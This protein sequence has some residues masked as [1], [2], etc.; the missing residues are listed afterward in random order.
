MISSYLRP[1]PSVFAC[2]VPLAFYSAAFAQITVPALLLCVLE[3]SPASAKALADALNGY[4]F[5]PFS[6]EL[7]TDFARAGSLYENDDTYT[8]SESRLT[9]TGGISPSPAD[10]PSAQTPAESRSEPHDGSGR[11]G[12]RPGKAELGPVSGAAAAVGTCLKS[13]QFMRVYATRLAGGAAPAILRARRKP[14]AGGDGEQTRPTECWLSGKP[15]PTEPG[16][17]QHSKANRVDGASGVCETATEDRAGLW[18]PFGA[19]AEQ[20]V[21]ASTGTRPAPSHAGPPG[22]A[23]GASQSK[24]APLCGGRTFGGKARLRRV[25]REGLGGN[26]LEAFAGFWESLDLQSAAAAALL[27][28]CSA[29][30]LLLAE[31]QLDKLHPDEAL[32]DAL[33]VV[34][35]MWQQCHL[36]SMPQAHFV[37]ILQRILAGRGESTTLATA[38]LGKAKPCP[39]SG[40]TE[41]SLSS[42]SSDGGRVEGARTGQGF[43]GPQTANVDFS[44]MGPEAAGPFIELRKMLET[45]FRPASSAAVLT[46][47][48]PAPLLQ[49]VCHALVS[50][51]DEEGTAVAECLSTWHTAGFLLQKAILRRDHLSVLSFHELQLQ[52]LMGRRARL[53]GL[54]GDPNH[55][56]SLTRIHRLDHLFSAK[57]LDSART[58]GALGLATVQDRLLSCLGAPASESG[59][60]GPAVANRRAVVAS[61]IDDA[62]PYALDA[63]RRRGRS[64]DDS[65]RGGMARCEDAAERPHSHWL[66]S[67]YE[68]L[69]RLNYWE[70]DSLDAAGE[71]THRLGAGAPPSGC[72]V[73]RRDLF[74][75]CLFDT[76]SLIHSAAVWENERTRPPHV[77]QG[78]MPARFSRSVSSKEMPN[79]GQ[80]CGNPGPLRRVDFSR[81]L[82]TANRLKAI[83]ISRRSVSVA[84]HRL[85][86]AQLLGSQLGEKLSC[87]H[88]GEGGTPAQLLRGCVELTMARDLKLAAELNLRRIYDAMGPRTPDREPQPV[89]SPGVPRRRPAISMCREIPVMSLEV[90]KK[91]SCSIST[92]VSEGAAPMSRNAHAA[93][94]LWFP[95]SRLRTSRCGRI[96]LA[97]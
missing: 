24:P 16:V 18:T 41:S 61:C 7:M 17:H 31:Q 69:W 77:R 40:T 59:A 82:E 76:L 46:P 8:P 6:A 43:R 21:S 71:R 74:N 53:Q 47:A 85:Q 28:G 66:E 89:A 68:C 13:L 9:R 90:C 75:G 95:G 39:G 88:G 64:R 72:G 70:A 49:L 55:F 91:L 45:T 5:R 51:N 3:T 10:G 48:G 12:R 87:F 56:S 29:D 52:D 27:L 97:F 20:E 44:E 92:R 35:Q 80:F 11:H 38:T 22:C 32:H 96:R 94:I 50:A 36:Q 65:L 79:S 57:I 78:S 83:Q 30:A 34:S 58:L 73:P 1:Y 54:D 2:F 60:P 4:V 37:K 63:T 67:R 81:V 62:V 23:S 25:L 86:D 93:S 26:I 15:A 42:S 19:A 14:E 33:S 84:L